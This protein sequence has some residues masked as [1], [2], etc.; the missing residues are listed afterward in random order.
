MST[1]A[2]PKTATFLSKGPNTMLTYETG[3][4]VKHDPL[5]NVVVPASSGKRVQ[6]EKH[7]AVIEPSETS[8]TCPVCT[9][10]GL[11]VHDGEAKDCPK[12]EGNGTISRPASKVNGALV[13]VPYER[14]LEWLRSH[15]NFNVADKNCAFWEE[16]NAPDEP[17]PTLTEQMSRLAEASTLQSLDLIGEVR[18]LE[19]QTHKRHAIL[20]ACEAAEK[21]IALLTDDTD[22]Q[23]E[24][25]G[26]GEPDESG[27]VLEGDE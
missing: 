22:P 23:A 25:Q 16:G 13:D 4:K 9:G 21:T 19:E 12:C 18:E 7:L 15:E 20:A 6:F 1:L 24:A 17:K 26:E 14:L 27:S 5:G 3:R 11:L 2:P 8:D 10:N